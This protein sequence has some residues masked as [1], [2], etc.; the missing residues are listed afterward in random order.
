MRFLKLIL[1]LFSIVTL[2]AITFVIVSEF[3]GMLSEIPLLALVYFILITILSI[4]HIVYH[5]KSFRFYRRKEKQ[6]LDK[7][8]SKFHWIGA[9]CL[10]AF[11]LFLLGQGI[12]NNWYRYWD[13]GYKWDDI[14]FIALFLIP[15][16][17]GFLEFFYLKKRIKEIIAMRDTKEE[18]NDIGT[19]ST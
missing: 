17:I 12:Y 7:K 19:S 1:I 10:Y 2:L 3:N 11:L 6:N 9:T 4:I 15:A 14:L 13:G 18:I 16:S 8:L 5:I